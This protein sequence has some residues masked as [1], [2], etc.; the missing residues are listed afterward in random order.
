MDNELRAT[1]GP[2]RAPRLAIAFALIAA[3]I[4]VAALLGLP[5]AGG[6]HP[7]DGPPL[8][9]GPDAPGTVATATFSIVG[10]D[11]ATG[12]VGVAVA[13][14]VLSV[15]SV[16]PW[17]KAGVGAVATQAWAN[18][19]YGP[20]G[21]AM[22]AEGATAAEVVKRL[23][24][25]DPE[26]ARR[27]L[28]VVDGKG[29]AAG[30]T[31]SG[32]HA[33]AGDRQ[34]KHYTAQGN[35]LAGEGVLEAMSK[36]YEGEDGDLPAKL[37]AALI[38]G[39]AAGGDRRGKQSAAILVARENAGYGGRSDR[40]IDLRVEDH[41]DPVLELARIVAIHRRFY[42]RRYTSRPPPPEPMPAPKDEGKKKGESP[43]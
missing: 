25:A 40:F 2:G 27:Q 1:T 3:G 6:E 15:G 16:V 39:D 21:L 7:A 31:G 14:K 20:D 37:I 29:G 42:R 17:A 32:C 13:S 33:W 30:F 8:R 34:G 23:T 43:Y 9:Y 41:A 24:D 36:A 35:I 22:L 18:V 19:D 12:E 11:P 38:A 5:P 26:A 10:W 28:G 4:G